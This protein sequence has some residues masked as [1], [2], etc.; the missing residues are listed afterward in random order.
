[1]KPVEVFLKVVPADEIEE[2]QDRCSILEAANQS[3]LAQ[4]EALRARYS[5]LLMLVKD[6]KKSL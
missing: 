1:M 5:E 4:L 3:S 2:L 6:L